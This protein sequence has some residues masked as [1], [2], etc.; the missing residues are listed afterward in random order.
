MPEVITCPQC[1]RQLRVPE[2]LVGQRVKCPTCGTNFTATVSGRSEPSAAVGELESAESRPSAY[3]EDN[4]SFRV[5]S[6]SEERRAKALSSTK[7]PAICLLVLY[8]LGLVCGGIN[9]FRVLTAPP[10]KVEDVI[11]MFPAFKGQEQQ[12]EEQLKFVAGPGG[13]TIAFI[14]VFMSLITVFGSIAMLAGRMRWL[15]ILGSIT[16][17]FNL[18]TCCCVLGLPFGIWSL[19]VLLNEDVKSAFE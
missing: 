8:G 10:P 11:K 18:G 6:P 4:E 3:E 7:A 13:A 5:H 1:E 2:E 9:V 15:A 19:V 17:M 12:I 14:F 16:A